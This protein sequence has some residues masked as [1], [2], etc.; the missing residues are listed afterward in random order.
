[1]RSTF[2]TIF[3]LSS[4]FSREGTRLRRPLNHSVYDNWNKV[5]GECISNDGKWIVY[6]VEP[7][8]GTAVVVYNSDTG[9]GGYCYAAMPREFPK[10]P[11]SWRLPSNHSSPTCARRR[12]PK[13]A[14]E[15]PKTHWESWNSEG[16]RHAHPR[17]KSFAFPEKGAGWIACHLLKEA[18][19]SIQASQ[20][21]DRPANG[22]DGKENEKKEEAGTTTLVA[23]SSPQVRNSNSFCQ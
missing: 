18:A 21:E 19:K 3:L 22:C 2:F 9:R 13:P 14:D 23:R 6:V 16:H 20:P 11:G 5:S 4:L 10:T 7:R 12:S 17:V 1:M 15:L 8:K